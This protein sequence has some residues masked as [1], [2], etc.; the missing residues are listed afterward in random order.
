MHTHTVAI[1]SFTF[2]KKSGFVYLVDFEGQ[3]Q[4][5]LKAESI[6]F[7]ISKFKSIRLIFL[8]F[9][10]GIVKSTAF[11]TLWLLFQELKYLDYNLMQKS[12]FKHVNSLNSSNSLSKALDL[13]NSA[14]NRRKMSIIDLNFEIK[15]FM[16][17][18]CRLV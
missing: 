10:A 11:C 15:R 16:D 4:T 13:T 8:L 5:S 2:H 14:K 1:W 9:F 18:A 12:Q 17:S 3:F 7:L 6:Y